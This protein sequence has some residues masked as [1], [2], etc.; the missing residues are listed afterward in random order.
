MKIRQKNENRFTACDGKNYMSIEL[1]WWDKTTEVDA[2]DEDGE[3][4]NEEAF[5]IL[6]DAIVAE[7]PEVF[8]DFAK[9]PK[10]RTSYK[11]DSDS[12]T[13]W[14]VLPALTSE[15]YLRKVLNRFGIALYTINKPTEWHAVPA[16]ARYS[17]SPELIRKGSR[18]LFKQTSYI[19]I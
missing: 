12:C 17:D 14:F 3:D 18:I 10:M 2:F 13:N 8:E 7:F 9:S 5:R 6:R 1:D 15:M 16:G 4:L 11:K 19:N